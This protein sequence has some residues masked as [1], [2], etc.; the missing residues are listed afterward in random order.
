MKRVSVGE[1]NIKLFLETVVCIVITETVTPIITTETV[2]W[3]MHCRKYHL[4]KARTSKITIKIVT[5]IFAAETV[6][7]ISEAETSNYIIATETVTCI[8]ATDVVT[9][10]IAIES[11]IVPRETVTAE[12][13]TPACIYL[14]KVNNQN[15]GTGSEI[16]SKLTIK[17]PEQPQLLAAG[18]FKYV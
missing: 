10:I 12:L 15:S 3:K 14:L 5:H 8:I 1:R 17:T 13:T 4:H 2:L 7:C 9:C 6:N 18:L 11:C 16:C